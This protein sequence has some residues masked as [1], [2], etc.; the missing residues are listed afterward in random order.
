VGN[1]S[2]I[3]PSSLVSAVVQAPGGGLLS[4]GALRTLAKETQMFPKSSRGRE[5]HDG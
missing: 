2:V 4:T 1:G 5:G 3:Y